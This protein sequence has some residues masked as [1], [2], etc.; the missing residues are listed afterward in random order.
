MRKILM[1][2]ALPYANGD[3]HLGHLVGYIQADI[4]R[5]FQQLQGNSCYYICADDTHGTPIMLNAEKQGIPPEQYIKQ[6]FDRH[7]RDFKNFNIEFSHYDTTHS[8]ENT[9]LSCQIFTALQDG[10]AI[11]K[12]TINQWYDSEK[13]IFLA[14]RYI[15]GNCPKCDASDQYGDN[16]EVCGATYDALQLNTPRSTLSNSTPE[17][18]KSLHYFFKLSSFSDILKQWHNTN[19][20]EPSIVNKLREW[21]DQGLQDWNI[22]RDAPYFGILIPGSDNKYFYVWLDAP[23]GY[24]SSFLNFCQKNNVD[25]DSYWR[26]TSTELHH[27]IGKD[28]INFHALFWPAMLHCAN[29]R[30]PTRINVNGF[31][32]ING[33]KMSK[34][35]DTF[36]LADKF[37]QSGVHPDCLRYYFA[38]KLSP[39][40]IDID[41]NIAQFVAKINSDIIGKLVNIGSRC[42]S[43]IMKL[44]DGKLSSNISEAP[45]TA[46]MSLSP[47]IAEL[48][49]NCEY[50]AA[51]KHIMAVADQC[52]Q[53]ISQTEPWAL[54]KNPDTQSRALDICS[55]A[56]NVYYRLSC[57]LAPIMPQIAETIALQM[58]RPICWPQPQDPAL[59]GT[60]LKF[61]PILNKIDSEV[62]NTNL[63]TD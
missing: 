17:I 44:N 36:I 42:S 26:E 18:R 8:T 63:F 29:Y 39:K 34:S 45:L 41:L 16:C 13:S 12:R 6:F 20:I 56:L 25:F 52:N 24:M 14:D 51:I 58:Q 59:T 35:R 11:E 7:Q 30:L 54:A 53:F 31:L 2:S 38:S 47:K 27:F 43:F 46:A 60:I 23:I 62:L 22:S 15:K 37:H 50:S 48:Y 19:S 40:P 9:Q 32:T 33:A 3:I 55:V 4:W 21:I 1:T 57:Y 49:E 61:K 10:G 5:R 28:I